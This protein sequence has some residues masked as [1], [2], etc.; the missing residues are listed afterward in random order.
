LAE[1]DFQG[2]VQLR[3]NIFVAIESGVVFSSSASFSVEHLALLMSGTAVLFSLE[4]AAI[5]LA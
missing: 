5:V 1:S 3:A 2:L 4:L